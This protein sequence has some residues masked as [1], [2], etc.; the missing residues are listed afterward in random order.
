MFN[1]NYLFFVLFDS[2]FMVIPNF[3]K[4]SFVISRCGRILYKLSIFSQKG[5]SGLFI[6]VALDLYSVPSFPIFEALASLS[7]GLM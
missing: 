4:S 7:I 5:S 6:N 2:S 1:V 3:S